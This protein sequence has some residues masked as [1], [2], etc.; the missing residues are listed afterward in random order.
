MLIC[1]KCERQF[2]STIALGTHKVYCGK[3]IVRNNIN[4]KEKK[5]KY[6]IINYDTF[7]FYLC[8]ESK[9]KI[10][11]F[12][13]QNESFLKKLYK[14]FNL[15]N[16]S[17]IK[18]IDKII[19]SNFK[20]SNILNINYWLER[21]WFDEI[22]LK[23]YISN[24]QKYKSKSTSKLPKTF[25]ENQKMPL[26]NVKDVNFYIENDKKEYQ[27][28][29][30]NLEELR[31]K[32]R[33]VVYH[34]S[35]KS[36][37][38][39][40]KEL[41]LKTNDLKT[42]ILEERYVFYSENKKIEDLKCEHC[43]NKKSYSFKNKNW[44]NT[45]GDEKC[46]DKNI[47]SIILSKYGVENVSNSI[48][49]Q[50][51][52]KKTNLKKY[53]TEYAI[54]SDIVRKKIEK[55]NYKKYG[56]RT[57]F[58]NLEIKKKAEKSFLKNILND[59][60]LLRFKKLNLSYIKYEN[61]YYHIQCLKC[62]NIFEIHY[63][64]LNQRYAKNY[65]ICTNC[66]P[67]KKLYS[68]AER[69]IS[70]HIQNM[71]FNVIENYKLNRKEIDIYL[72]D[73]NIGFEYNGL[74]WHSDKFKHKNHLLEKKEHFK[75]LNIN[76]YNIWSDDWLYKKDIVLSRI[77]NILG[78]SNKIYARK[79]VLKSVNKKE[80]RKFLNDNHIQGFVNSKFAYGLYYNNM[81]ISIMT[82]GKL[83][84]NLG[85]KN[86]EEH[87]ELL[88]FCNIKNVSVIGG[89][90]KLL[91]HFTKEVSYKN[92]I[93]YADLCWS[94]GNLYKQLGF[95]LISIT[96]PNYFYF[97]LDKRLNRF[98]FR[99]DVLIKEGYDPTKTEKQI[100]Q[101]RGY[102]RVYDCGSQKWELNNTIEKL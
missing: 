74:V 33:N 47:K 16:F 1:E 40:L 69:D 84:K 56:V 70:Q 90:S 58:E 39:I 51:K 88:R 61:K 59:K 7:L 8:N 42:D 75:K 17:S 62:K 76:I 21:G 66:N 60:M 50:E 92:I 32:T 10:Q 86:K 64:L 4:K 83:R 9:L 68:L 24:L 89:A 102:Y 80:E 6:H 48:I 41:I 45:C 57:P 37:E 18:E 53:G 52:K 95:N 5:Y 28:I 94:N 49:I 26:Y 54:S 3:N 44:N 96:K 78:I 97:K 55:T 73:L 79:C 72:P 22:F 81:L 93:S 67:I 13:L 101:E 82:F 36:N 99:K 11:F 71:G 29:A 23:N 65:P 91:K 27:I 30:K 87:F 85:Q 35:K 63:E 15:K 43:H 20:T 19:L 100:M 14:N 98:K 34:L 46:I 38:H 25:Y 2:E 77:N 31:S 12:N